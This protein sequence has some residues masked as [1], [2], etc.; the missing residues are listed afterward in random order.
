MKRGTL[1]LLVVMFVSVTAAALAHV[2][3]RLGVIRMAYTISE[4][5]SARRALEQKHRKLLIER[6]LLRSPERIERLA[7]DKLGMRHPA[8]SQLRAPAQ[9]EPR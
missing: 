8:P 4:A 5:S 6:S 3:L 1:I 9:Q 7:R 2:S